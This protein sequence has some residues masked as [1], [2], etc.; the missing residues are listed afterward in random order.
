M[1]NNNNFCINEYFLNK[2]LS[3]GKFKNTKNLKFIYKY[4]TNY[5]KFIFNNVYKVNY[6]KFLKFL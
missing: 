6:V 5:F 3:F 4:Y 2:P 1:K